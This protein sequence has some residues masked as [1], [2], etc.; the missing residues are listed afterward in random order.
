MYAIVPWHGFPFHD[1]PRVSTTYVVPRCS[2]FA[3]VSRNTF[4]ASP[5]ISTNALTADVI[6]ISSPASVWNT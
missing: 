1:M 4:G 5:P 6:R 2:A 3:V